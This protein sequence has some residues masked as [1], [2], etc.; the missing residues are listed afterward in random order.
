[1]LSG[2]NVG[3]HAFHVIRRESCTTPKHCLW[4]WPKHHLS[5]DRTGAKDPLILSRPAAVGVLMRFTVS[6]TSLRS[7]KGCHGYHTTFHIMKW[8]EAHSGSLNSVTVCSI[9]RVNAEW[10]V[11]LHTG[12]RSHVFYC[13]P[14][15][16]PKQYGLLRPR[17][18]SHH[19]IGRR[20]QWIIEFCYGLKL[21]IC[22]RTMVG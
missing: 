14:R 13:P 15:T 7:S 1:M 9:G 12:V 20:A 4:K 22:Q 16:S 21:W 8:A 11:N 10:L 3:D 2:P 19:E 5:N 18:L 17:E 6:H